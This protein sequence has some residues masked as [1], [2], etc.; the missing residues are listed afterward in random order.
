M[1]YR[2][3]CCT[4]VGAVQV[5]VLHNVSAV[6]VSVRYSCRCNISVGAAQCQC[7]RGVGAAQVS[8]L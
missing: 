1:L 8:V 7:C 4:G 5:L 2:C 3:Q 6:Q